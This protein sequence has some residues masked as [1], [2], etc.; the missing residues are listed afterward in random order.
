MY[1]VIV[2]GARCGGAPT[3]MLLA[4]QGLRVLLIDKGQF[5]GDVPNGHFVHR[6]GPRLLKKWG[7][8]DK[9]VASG[10]PAITHQN[11]NLGDFT[12]HARGMELDG[13]AWGYG[14]RRKVL[15]QILIDAAVAAGAE[16]RPR[17]VVEGF[18][19]EGARITGIRGRS[20]LGGVTIR[21]YADITVGADGRKS[22]LA[23]TVGAE[24]YDC[25]P[26]Q[27]CCYFSYWSG[28]PNDQF[29]MYAREGSAV[30]SFATNDG[31]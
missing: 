16:F 19:S 23:R 2:V 1:D 10:C 17:F 7:L 9:V 24:H 22:S 12:L 14:P 28:V 27:T 6:G 25:S 11:S 13:V 30:F 8:L 31:L 3:A 21:E 4:R 26:P 18:E 5:P 20:V 29:E 15:D